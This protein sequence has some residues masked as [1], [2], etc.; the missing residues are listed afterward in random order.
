MA[1]TFKQKKPNISV[2]LL[3]GVAGLFYDP[4]IQG[5][6]LTKIL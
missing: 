4:G 5:I 6:M 3:V 2:W 1:N